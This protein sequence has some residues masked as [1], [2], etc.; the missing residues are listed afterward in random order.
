MKR[1]YEKAMEDQKQL[2][3]EMAGLKKQTEEAMMRVVEGLDQVRVAVAD[4]E[5]DMLEFRQKD[6]EENIT[7]SGTADHILENF[8]NIIARTVAQEEHAKLAELEQTFQRLKSPS[9]PELY[10]SAYD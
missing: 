4:V 7:L 1:I 2:R 8:E 3:K 10:C 5:V 9:P 6:M